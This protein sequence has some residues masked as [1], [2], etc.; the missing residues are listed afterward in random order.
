MWIVDSSVWI[1]YF[2][3]VITPQTDLLDVSLGQQAI[4]VGDIILCKVLQ[5][6]RHERDFEIARE[7]L[8]RFPV[9]DLGGTEIAIKSAQNYRFLRRKGITIRKTV[10]C[11][12]ATFV[13]ENRFA[14][15][16]DDY[17]FD[18]F[19]LHLGLEIVLA[20]REQSE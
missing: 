5:G 4:G 10:D 6:F 20:D 16:H 17:D 9:Y 18:P 11:L 14:L 13:I 15:L 2:D 19:E 8:L 12:I 7:L 3:G 1:D